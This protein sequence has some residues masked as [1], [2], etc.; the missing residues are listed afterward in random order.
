[1]AGRRIAAMQISHGLPNIR[2]WLVFQS[3]KLHLPV[4]ILFLEEYIH[5]KKYH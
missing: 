2:K 1:V 3:Q 5:N 4:E